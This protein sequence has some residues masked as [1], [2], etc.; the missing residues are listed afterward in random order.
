MI[1][2]AYE[3]GADT[4]PSEV[5]YFPSQAQSN[6]Y[7]LTYVESKRPLACSP[8]NLSEVDKCDVIVAYYRPVRPF[9]TVADPYP[10]K[11]SCAIHRFLSNGHSLNAVVKHLDF[12][13]LPGASDIVCTNALFD[14]STNE[15][16]IGI[17]FV[18]DRE[19]GY[20][21]IYGSTSE[22]ELAECCLSFSELSAMPLHLTHTYYL[23][24]STGK[25]QWA[26]ILSCGNP[27]KEETPPSPGHFD[28]AFKPPVRVFAQLCDTTTPK[29]PKNNA[30]PDSDRLCST[31]SSST[32][33]K[34]TRRTSSESINTIYGE[35][36]VTSAANLFP[37]L[38]HLPETTILYMDFVIRSTV[39]PMIRLA[40]F[41]AQDGWFAVYETDMN[42]PAVLRQFMFSHDSAITHVKLF[43]P[44]ADQCDFNANL[45]CKR[46]HG[47]EKSGSQRID[48]LVCSAF[49]SA[50]VYT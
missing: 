1:K 36:S 50:V 37:E 19:K 22:E 41:G 26:F 23:S 33:P 14:S 7:N 38:A 29:E 32:E 17:G 39:T 6:I 8:G 30:V 12:V 13:Y 16:V 34:T 42:Q 46:E 45:T 47:S 4:L 2:R 21:N 11:H 5:F 10:N 35:L 49:E 18:K 24:P 15:Y 44:D 31:S 25:L 9:I 3:A 48:L 28:S 20:L 43:N 40:A 27:L